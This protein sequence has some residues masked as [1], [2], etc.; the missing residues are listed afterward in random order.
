MPLPGS[1]ATRVRFAALSSW[2]AEDL[3]LG[4]LAEGHTDA[5]A[6]LAEAGREPAE[7][8]AAY[9]VW[10][11]RGGTSGTTAR[12]DSDGWHL[13]GHKPFCS[14]YGL[15][16]RA[17]VTADTEDGY[18]LFDIAIA[19]NVVKAEPDS[20]QAV[21]MADSAS[22]T[23]EFGGPPLAA[24]RIIGPPDWYLARPG[25]WLG[26]IGVAACWFGGARGLVDNL[27]VSLGPDPSDLV[28][29]EL[30]R[31]VAH[32]RTMQSVIEH[33]A[34]AIDLDPAG[35]GR[36]LALSVRYAVHHSAT[37]VL[38][39]TAAAGGA[40]PLC[41]DRTQARRAADLYVYLAQHHGPFDAVELG[42]LALAREP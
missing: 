27:A 24:E 22:D 40:R 5:L 30:G 28:T 25:F 42:R 12:R 20:W 17:L 4:R 18:R 10:A 14:G 1:G 33:A 2:A 35:I 32:V 26:A 9:G 37:Q 13:S 6:I 3:S 16:E 23:L 38:G 36:E 19:E 21:G 29:A 15:I 7:P 41:H 8:S 11:A 31:A 34:A 39:H